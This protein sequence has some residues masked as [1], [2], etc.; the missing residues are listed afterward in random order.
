[1]KNGEEIFRKNYRGWRIGL[2]IQVPETAI[3]ITIL[4]LTDLQTL[5]A[6]SEPVISIDQHGGNIDAGYPGRAS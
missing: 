4:F 2:S 1:M 6:V 3:L 5:A